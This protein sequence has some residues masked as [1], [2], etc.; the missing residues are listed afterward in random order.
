MNEGTAAVALKHRSKGLCH[1]N[2]AVDVD[3]KFG[4]KLFDDILVHDARTNEDACVRNDDL[5]VVR[6]FCRGLD[7]GGIFIVDLNRNDFFTKFCY[8]RFGFIERANACVDF[9]CTVLEK[10]FDDGFTDASIGTSHE[11]DFVRNV[12]AHILAVNRSG[13]SFNPRY[14]LIGEGVIGAISPRDTSTYVFAEE[15][16]HGD[17]Y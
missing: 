6:S 2:E 15:V 4:L 1:T 10:S 12:I 5:D 11:G 9:G 16:E 8:E 14:Y 3:V 7:G 17:D 13:Q